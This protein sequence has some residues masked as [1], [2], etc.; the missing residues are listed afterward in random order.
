MAGRG[1]AR[2]VGE[3][4]G[5]GTKPAEQISPP[6]HSLRPIPPGDWTGH[7]RDWWRTVTSSAVAPL[8]AEDDW[9]KCY[10]LLFMVDRWWRLME[11][12][13]D[14]MA[15]TLHAEIR[16]TESLLYLSMVDRARAGLRSDPPSRPS[17]G[18]SPGPSDAKSR[19]RALG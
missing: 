16:R 4:L 18:P 14:R 7:A 17:P 19:L 13:D 9:D 8:W 2:K 1:P 6:D 11:S 10:R 15:V 3:R 12:G 5:H